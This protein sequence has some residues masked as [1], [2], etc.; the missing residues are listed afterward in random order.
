MRAW[1]VTTILMAVALATVS[2]TTVELGE[3]SHD[4]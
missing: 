4:A 1:F 2:D 3:A